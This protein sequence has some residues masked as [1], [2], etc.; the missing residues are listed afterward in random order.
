MT[1]HGVTEAQSGPFLG[2]SVT[3]CL[4]GQFRWDE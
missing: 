2:V 1:S 4:C 3:L